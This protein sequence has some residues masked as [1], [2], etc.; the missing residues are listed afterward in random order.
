[1]T[2]ATKASA[3]S[4]DIQYRP[5]V[6]NAIKTKYLSATD[7][8]G[9]RIQATTHQG[10]RIT[11]SW[12]YEL[13]TDDNHANAARQWIKKF[14]SEDVQLDYAGLVFGGDYYWTWKR[15]DVETKF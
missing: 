2:K 15:R 4:Q 5:Q 13:N 6:S 8:R 12:D 7:F 14:G 11:V 9:S 10:L 1:M 3:T